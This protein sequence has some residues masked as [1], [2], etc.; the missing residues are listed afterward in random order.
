M[1]EFDVAIVGFGPTGKLLARLLSDEGH[2]VAVVERWPETYPL[3]RAIAYFHD[4]KRMFHAIGMMREISRISRPMDR[5]QWYNANWEMLVE[6]GFGGES[7]SGGPEGYT[8]SQPDLEDILDRDLRQR[9]NVT[10]FKG[11]EAQALTQDDGGASLTIRPFDVPSARVSEGP[12]QVLR[13]QYVVGC[14]GANSM[15]RTAMGTGSKDLGFDARWLV[16][17]IKPHD[18]AAH[19]IPDAAQW[20][21]PARPTTIVP[22]GIDKRR[23]EFMMAPEEDE[24][25]FTTDENVWSMIDQW[26]KPGEGEIIRKAV[27]N[28]RS[29]IAEKWRDGRLLLAGDA[30]HLMPPFMGQGMNSGLRDALT[31]GFELDLVLKRQAS[32]SLLD[33][34]QKERADHVQSYIE[35]SMEMGKVVCILDEAAAAERDAAFAAGHLPPPPVP[36]VLTDGLV[37]KNGDAVAPGAGVLMPHAMLKTPLGDV[38]RLDN[39]AGRR[40][41]V[42]TRNGAAAGLDA[43]QRAALARIDAAVIDLDSTH[44]ETDGKLAAFL[45]RHGADAVIARPDFHSFGVA[46]TPGALAALVDELA[47]GLTA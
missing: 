45:D 43:V 4:T 23:W 7:L 18:M 10:F 24:A 41:F 27:Y 15:V 22:C 26:I 13:A 17:D 42:V 46:A 37:A 9:G 11:F 5:Y 35:L 14:D 47:A 33:N 8:F 1:S 25:S 40:F 30:A 20:C 32:D 21:N 44:P 39:V 19:D 31:L 12:D 38:E 16:V 2:S 3:P 29:L 28:F 34:Y 36:P 6:L